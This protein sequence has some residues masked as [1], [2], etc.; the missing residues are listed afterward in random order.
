MHHEDPKSSSMGSPSIA[1]YDFEAQNCL[2]SCYDFR[3]SEAQA[4]EITHK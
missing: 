2:P 4:E 1:D 3:K